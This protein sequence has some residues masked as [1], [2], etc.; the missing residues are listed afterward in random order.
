MAFNSVAQ[1]LRPINVVVWGEEAMGFL[2][3]V[4]LLNSC[5]LVPSD[6]EYDLAAQKLVEAGFRPAPWTYAITDPQLVRDDEIGRRTLLRGDDGYGNL[7]ANSLRFQF[8]AGFSGSER[9]VLLRSTY[10]GIRPPSDPESMQ[11]FS[12]NDNLYYPDAVLL[13]ESFIKTLLQEIPGSWRH[14]L[15]AW[16][17]AYIYGMLMVKDTVL[18]SCDAESV[19]LWFNERIRRGNG[20]LDRGTVSKR[21]GKFRAPTK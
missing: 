19:K 15:Q 21:A 16:A 3:A 11:R 10:V 14:L 17:I 13:L 2:G 8:P 5:M 18:D 7:D 4:T 20:G 1:V 12:C 9:V 6:S